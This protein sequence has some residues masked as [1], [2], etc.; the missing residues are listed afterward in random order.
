VNIFVVWAE[1][2]DR[3]GKPTLIAAFK[4]A[5][6]AERLRL[7]IESASPSKD[8]HVDEVELE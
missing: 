5:E 3:S 8:V 6:K 7:Q 2:S 1:Y 4:S